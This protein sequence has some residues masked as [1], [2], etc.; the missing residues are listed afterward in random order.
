MRLTK[1]DVL[2]LAVIVVTRQS[3]LYPLTFKQRKPREM[4]GQ[5]MQNHVQTNRVVAEK[6]NKVT[7][8][9]QEARKIYSTLDHRVFRFDPL[10]RPVDMDRARK[11]ADEIEKDNNL[12]LEYPIIVNRDF[13]VI[14]GQHRLHA[15]IMANVAIYYVVSDVMDMDKAADAVGRTVGWKMADYLHHWVAK[16]NADYV[17]LERFWKEYP[18]L[19]ISVLARICSSNNYKT[20]LFKSGFY[21]ADRIVFGEKVAKMALDFKPYFDA[22]NHTTFLNTVMQLAANDKYSHRRMMDKLK[23]QS[24]SL[25]RCA[26]VDLYLDLISEIYNH[27]MPESKR[28]FFRAS[29]KINV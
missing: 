15:A 20:D 6:E 27:R 14:D 18:W 26:T 19:N 17:Q 10:N 22:Y 11:I 7:F 2:A 4:Y 23:Y 13:V 29:K 28:V 25:R 12:L 24:N 5:V 8:H 16:G 3:L 9:S 21:K 1:T